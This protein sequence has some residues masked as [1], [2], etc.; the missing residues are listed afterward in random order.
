MQFWL[1]SISNLSESIQKALGQ[2]FPTTS[3]F[4]RVLTCKDSCLLVLNLKVLAELW[5]KYLTAVIQASIQPFKD[6]L[7]S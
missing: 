4:E 5:Y 2:T 6:T 3:L 1:G 7:G